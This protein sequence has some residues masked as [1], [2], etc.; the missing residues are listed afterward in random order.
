MAA[1]KKAKKPAPKKRKAPK[2]R[3]MSRE[4][5]EA[6]Q[7]AR[8]GQHVGRGR[9]TDFKDEFVEIARQMC[10]NGATDYDLAQEFGV[11]TV[12]IW[13]WQ[14]THTDFCNALV[15]GK[16]AFDNRV[17]RSLAQ[18]AVG[19]TYHSEKIIAPKQ[20]TTPI[21]VPVVEHLPPDISAAK[22]WLSNRRKDQWAGSDG[23]TVNVNT[24]VN[25]ADPRQLMELARWMAFTMTAAVAAIPAP[26]QQADDDEQ[27]LAED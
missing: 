27:K 9:P 6:A 8:E 16:G 2:K 7:A 4:I 26:E 1:A 13:R 22:H 17:E 11:T 21:R 12:S 23:Q 20:G 14:A 15:V 24:Q 5:R 3:V 25:L 10:A 18:R 19:Y